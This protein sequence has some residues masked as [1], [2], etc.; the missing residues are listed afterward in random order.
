MMDQIVEYFGFV[1][2]LLYLFWEIRQNNLMWIVGILS[3]LAYIVLF[4]QSELYASMCFQVYYL[5]ISIY[6]LMVWQREKRSAAGDIDGAENEG[7]RIV[8]RV[9]G[10]KE[11]V[12]ALLATVLIFVLLFLFLEKFTGDP[13]PATDAVITSLSIVA[14]YWLG[15][16]YLQQ[17]LLWIIADVLS[18]VLFF[19]QGLYPTALLYVLY[20]ICAVYGFVHWR[21]K[22]GRL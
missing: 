7:S 16:L 21:K 18:V 11:A 6:G 2:G 12:V 19:S 17:W 4:A 20:T 3:A 5:V 15:K 14:T 22:G 10:I 13:M 9:A 1:T 8:Y